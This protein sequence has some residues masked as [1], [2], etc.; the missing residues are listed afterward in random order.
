MIKAQTPPAWVK[1]H[2]NASWLNL[3]WALGVGRGVVWLETLYEMDELVGFDSGLDVLGG[4]VC[5]SSIG[6]C[7]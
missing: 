3:A 2:V 1:L 5:Q 6:S 4:G 7:G